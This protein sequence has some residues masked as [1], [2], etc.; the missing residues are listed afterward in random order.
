VA[1]RRG[2]LNADRFGIWD[3]GASNGTAYSARTLLCPALEGNAAIR[4]S[5]GC[6]RRPRGTPLREGGGSSWRYDG[7]EQ[8]EPGQ[9]GW[10]A[11]RLQDRHGGRHRTGDQLPCAHPI[12]MTVSRHDEHPAKSPGGGNAV[13]HAVDSRSAT[14]RAQRPLHRGLG[15]LHLFLIRGK[16]A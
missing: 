11:D 13:E 6:R 4:C 16:I 2:A 14:K 12:A 1:A 5:A 8:L 15:F 9:L 10:T 3:H 7:S